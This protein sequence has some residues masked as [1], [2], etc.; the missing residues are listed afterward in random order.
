MIFA[1][2]I[3]ANQKNKNCCTHFMPGNF[4][5]LKFT[6]KILEQTNTQGQELSVLVPS[7]RV[8]CNWLY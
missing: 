3:A 4:K 1:V 7:I 2:T 5:I 6:L 8:L